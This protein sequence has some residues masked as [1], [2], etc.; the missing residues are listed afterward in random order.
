MKRIAFFGIVL[1]AGLAVT[2]AYFIRRNSENTITPGKFREANIVLITIDTLRADHLPAY[3]YT[4]LSTP[5]MDR[6]AAESVLF[7][8]A[9]AHVPMTLPS[10]ASILTGLLPVEHAV[11]DN[12]GFILNEKIKTLPEILKENG[13]NTAAF[14][15]AFVLDSQFGLDQGFDL[16]SD[17]FS[18]AEARVSSTDLHRRAAETQREVDAWLQKN[19]DKKFFLWVHYYDPH[20]PYE[21]PEPYQTQYSNSLY[22]GEIAYIDEILGKFLTVLDSAGLKEK[23]ILALTGDHGEGLGEHNEQT[24]ALFIYNST[25]HVPLM[26]RIPGIP[27]RR[28]GQIVGHSD[29]APTLLDLVGIKTR[30]RM[31]GKSLLPD[32]NGKSNS[33]RQAYSESLLAELHYGWSPLRSITTSQYKFIEA[34]TVEL[35]DRQIDRGETQNVAREKPEI[36]SSLRKELDAFASESN[37]TPAKVDQETEEKLKALGYV[38]TVSP[39]TSQ[40]RKS[41]PKN[42]LK[43]LNA[44]TYAGKAN[45]ALNYP[46]VIATLTPVLQQEP[47]L[48]DAHYMMAN[49]YLHLGKTELALQEFL[50][51]VKLKPDHTKTLYNLGFF[52]HTQENF[53]AAEYWYKQLLKYEPE[54]LFGNLNLASLYRQTGQTEKAKQYVTKVVKEYEQSI[55]QAASPEVRSKLLEKLSE[56]RFKTGERQQSI[57]DLEESTKTDPKNYEAWWKLG[58]LYQQE[59]RLPDAIDCQKKSIAVNKEFYPAYFSLSA[60]YLA[61]NTNLQEAL[62]LVQ[63]AQQKQPGKQADQLKAAIQT[64][65]RTK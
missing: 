6:L 61:T 55:R 63:T 48:V 3:G 56:I 46:L 57:N 23:T 40:S 62:R 2:V 30:Q 42:K 11:H 27:A 60:L 13:Y 47:Q 22:D 51:I 53:S 54:H 38:G 8:D 24:H 25:Q 18:L 43:I 58:S 16:Y 49:A 12:A 36:V 19:K 65:L 32:L 33:K 64:K 35:Y 41:D 29:L 9:I 20:D 52:Y 34:P 10:H 17:D 45:E 5:A 21:P 26:F 1:L 44:I 31:Q 37:A 39:G 15:S 7:E 50:T 14:I 4:K 59:G 28:V